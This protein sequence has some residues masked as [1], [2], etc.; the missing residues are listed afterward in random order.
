MLMPQLDAPSSKTIARFITFCMP[1]GQ[2]AFFI[3]TMGRD[4]RVSNARPERESWDRLIENLSIFTGFG[5][6][7]GLLTWLIRTLIDYRRWTRR[8]ESASVASA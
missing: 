8:Q 5:M 1:A 7:I 4:F 2:S 3:G 6:A